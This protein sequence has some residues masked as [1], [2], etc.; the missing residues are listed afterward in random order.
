MTSAL[1]SVIQTVFRDEKTVCIHDYE[2]SAETW[3]GF[4]D[5]LWDLSWQVAFEDVVPE[6]QIFLIVG[7]RVVTVSNT[8]IPVLRTV[9]FGRH[10]NAVSWAVCHLLLLSRLGA[11]CPRC[12]IVIVDAANSST[13]G[14]VRQLTSLCAKSNLSGGSFVHNII[15][16]ADPSLAEIAKALGEFK[17]KVPAVRAETLEVP[18]ILMRASITQ[19]RQDHHALGNVLSAYLLLA[20]TMTESGSPAQIVPLQYES[21]ILCKAL[22]NS[23]IRPKKAGSFPLGQIRNDGRPLLTQGDTIL[24]IDDMADLWKPVLEGAFPSAEVIT[25]P[26]KQFVDCLVGMSERLEKLGL[27]QRLS[28]RTITGIQSHPDSQ[29]FILFLDLRL[30]SE[31]D[32]N[33]PK[34]YK[35]LAE[36]GTKLAEEGRLSP[37]ISTKDEVTQWKEFSNEVVEG[38]LD[39]A[40][41]ILGKL[42][43]CLDPTLPIVLFSSTHARDLTAP[44]AAHHNVFTQFRKPT[45]AMLPTVVIRELKLEFAEAV[46]YAKRLLKWRRLFASLTASSGASLPKN[47]AC[48][49]FFDESGRITDNEMNIS[50]VGVMTGARQNLDDFHKALHRKFEDKLSPGFSSFHPHGASPVMHPMPKRPQN[51][52]DPAE[53]VEHWKRCQ[54]MAKMVEEVA[55]QHSVSVFCFSLLFDPKKHNPRWLSRQVKTEEKQ[56]LDLGYAVPMVHLLETLLFDFLG[57]SFLSQNDTLN[58]GLHFATRQAASSL[59][60]LERE[61]RS[62]LLENMVGRW[63][64]RTSVNNNQD[65]TIDPPISGRTPLLLVELA[66]HQRPIGD[67]SLDSLDV[68]R[69]KAHVLTNWKFENDQPVRTTPGREDLLPLPLHY[70]ADIL[71]NALRNSAE[72]E[73]QQYFL[74]LQPM[75]DW[76]KHGVFTADSAEW[77]DILRLWDCGD[78]V[79]ALR[80]LQSLVPTVD[81]QSA[82]DYVRTKISK[83]DFD[84]LTS[85][86][87]KRLVYDS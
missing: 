5:K 53:W 84:V 35:P 26:T 32:V 14:L 86:E 73:T 29:D 77:S 51:T 23:D 71:A 15:F 20:A 74:G 64:L 27:N 60:D 30:M 34:V 2:D 40:E 25:V 61:E 78:R 67:E 16:L 65:Q 24:L 1:F 17:I 6:D 75:R 18:A 10:F 47:G 19:E 39:V 58:L 63:G 36:L 72:V 66:L 33:R 54:Q 70:V 80:R 81:W 13:S 31:N 83:W 69:A 68:S 42:L 7:S 43:S 38:G 21:A 87:I 82:D 52:N 50:G 79:Q 59:G 9:D 85:A 41:P 48:D 28:P 37:W 57:V 3:D 45:A 12:G 46:S 62:D 55:G 49:L 44:F 11:K 8:D 56:L 4:R 76:R 22:F